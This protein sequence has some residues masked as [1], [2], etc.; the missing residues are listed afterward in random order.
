MSGIIKNA[1]GAFST[2]LERW[3]NEQEAGL[4]GLVYRR[5]GPW[6]GDNQLG[7]A[8]A[9]PTQAGVTGLA[10]TTQSASMSFKLDEIDLP[11]IWTVALSL[12]QPTSDESF[13]PVEAVANLTF[14]CGGAQQSLEVNV[15]NGVVISGPANSIDV[16]IRFDDEIPPNDVPP[17]LEIAY[18]ISRYAAAVTMVPQRI[19]RQTAAAADASDE[20]IVPKFARALTLM[21]VDEASA[22]ALFTSAANYIAFLGYDGSLMGV[23]PSTALAVTTKIPIPPYTRYVQYVNDGGTPLDFRWFFDIQF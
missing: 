12:Q 11:Q 23:V 9:F 3:G 17:G 8:R 7:Q 19:I 13:S 6:T 10:G 2:A 14:G 21:A 18:T 4:L 1:F 5:R 16:I 20:L 15:Q 22:A